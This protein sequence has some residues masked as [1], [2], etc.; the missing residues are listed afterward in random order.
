MRKGRTAKEKKKEPAKPLKKTGRSREIIGTV[1]ALFA[2]VISGIS[3]PLNKIFVVDI[4]PTIFTAVRAIIIG[5]VFLLLSFGTHSLHRNELKKHWKYLALI[6]VIGGAFAFLMFFTGLS[7]TTAGRAAFLQKTLPLYIAVFAFIFLKERIPRK[8]VYALGLMLAGTFFIFASQI[9]PTEWWSN[10]QMGDMLIIGAAI[11]WAVENVAARKVMTEGGNHLVVSFARMFFGGVILFGVAA[12]VN[13]L[14]ML[15]YLTVE[16]WNNIFVSVIFLFAYVYFW[17]RSIRYINV[18][19]AS[20]LLLLAPVVSLLIGIMFFG[21]PLPVIQLLGSVLI[22][23]GAY[24]VSSIKS[25]L[26]TGA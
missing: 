16:Q 26:R 4:D 20:A 8:Q 25:E 18:S 12:F 3:I 15:F 17:Y 24:F 14:D 19:K 1:F 23:I 21:E 2:A 10:P 6:A 22:L 7:L 13:R 5:F 9:E 11:M